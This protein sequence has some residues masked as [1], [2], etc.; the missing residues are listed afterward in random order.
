MSSPE[1]AKVSDAMQKLSSG[2]TAWS[3]RSG[4]GLQWFGHWS[5]GCT[6]RRWWA[7]RLSCC[8][9]AGVKGL[10]GSKPD[11]AKRER[12]RERCDEVP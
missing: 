3:S 8:S 10:L 9:Q 7:S 11:L 4:G 2:W 5:S 1:M 12:E 6:W